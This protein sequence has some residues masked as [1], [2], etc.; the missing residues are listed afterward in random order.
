[1]TM[2]FHLFAAKNTKGLWVYKL[3]TCTSSDIN[4]AEQC[5]N[6]KLSTSQSERMAI[7]RANRKLTSCPCNIGQM[8][9]DPRFIASSDEIG[10]YFKIHSAKGSTFTR[11][12]HDLDVI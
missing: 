10:C 8:K 4:Y 9:A 2:I 1:M 5:Y 11:V 7:S 3:D 6:W 12:W